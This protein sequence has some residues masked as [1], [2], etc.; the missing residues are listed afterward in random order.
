MKIRTFFF[1]LLVL[2][3]IEEKP[4]VSINNVTQFEG[5][6]NNDF[7][8]QV[9]LSKASTELVTVGYNTID[10]TATEGVDYVGTSGTLEFAPSETQ[11]IIRVE[12]IAD[13]LR[14]ETDEFIVSLSSPVGAT[15]ST[16]EGIGAI[17]NDDDYIFVPDD[18]YIT[19]ETYGGYT[20]AW[21]DEFNGILLS[22]QEKILQENTPPLEWLQEIKKNLD[23]EELILELSYLTVKEFGLPCGC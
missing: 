15:L 11:K 4:R 8:F 3:F 6:V 7:E 12:I 20:K 1:Y 13:T 14:E 18:G 10:D 22:K 23:L 17:R 2:I 19:P 5:D 9:M 16:G 21:A